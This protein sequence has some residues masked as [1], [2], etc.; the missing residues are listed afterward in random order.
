M[1][2]DK[3]ILDRIVEKKRER[4]QE[5]GWDLEE[6]VGQV[7]SL[8]PS[9]EPFLF[10]KA[11]AKEGISIIGEI[12][13]ASPS[14][15][16]IKEDFRPLE[17]AREYEGAVDAISVL[18]EEDFFQGSEAYLQAV[19][20][21][22][23][24][25]TLYKDFIIDKVQVYRAKLAGASCILLIVAILKEETLKELLELAES[26]GMDALVET[27]DADEI[28]TALRAGA[29]IVG[30]NNR[31]LK[32]FA[33]DLDLTLELA[34]L[35]PEGVL[36]I[37]ESGIDTMEDVQKLAGAGVDGILVGESFMRSGDIKAKAEAFKK[38]GQAGNH[39]G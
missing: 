32:T 38:G 11:M 10:Y 39:A 31:N 26:L 18:T 37:S 35:I 13:K 23:S 28:Q 2:Q 34:D 4:L 1:E 33:T 36:L 6:L 24:L 14:K 7:N 15:G 16:V 30:V 25:P 22:V 20:Q 5:K 19:S 12:K 29:R 3:N 21:A 9:K 17:L 27:H 8:E